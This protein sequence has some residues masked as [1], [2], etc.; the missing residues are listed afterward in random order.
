MVIKDDQ[1]GKA[2][3]NRALFSDLKANFKKLAQFWNRTLDHVNTS[4]D[5]EPFVHDCTYEEVFDT[6]VS[7]MSAKV[8]ERI[9]EWKPEW[10]KDSKQ[11]HV[12]TID[13][14]VF[15]IY[16]EASRYFRDVGVDRK[17]NIVEGR[18]AYF[19][20]SKVKF[21]K[22]GT[23]RDQNLRPRC[24]HETR[25]L[26]TC[27]RLLLGERLCFC[28]FVCFSELSPIRPCVKTDLQLISSSYLDLPWK[29]RGKTSSTEK[30]TVK[31]A[32]FLG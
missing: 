26:T 7:C 22:G 6:A 1:K 28:S 25:L 18:H 2:S 15:M 13:Y 16:A 9:H 5:N 17:R 24:V 29:A 32:T 3:E 11:C 19:S 20:G 14:K 4:L 31:L 23:V 8:G 10:W 21:Q 27:T 30:S 12:A